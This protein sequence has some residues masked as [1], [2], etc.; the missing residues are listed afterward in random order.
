MNRNLHRIISNSR[1]AIALVSGP[2]R[3]ILSIFVISILIL[4][5]Y[6]I[7]SNYRDIYRIKS[8]EASSLLRSIQKAG[9][10]AYLS[11]M[12][13][14]SLVI[15]KLLNTAMF[16]SLLENKHGLSDKELNSI[17]RANNIDHIYILSETGRMEKRNSNAPYSELQLFQHFSGEIDSILSGRYDYFVAGTVTDNNGS[18]HLLVIH[19]RDDGNKGIIAISVESNYLL[20]FRMRIGVGKLF[21]KIADGSDIAYIAIQ[22]TSGIITA[23]K[24][25]EQLSSLRTDEFLSGSIKAR[26][27]LTREYDFKDKS[28]F[29]AVKPFRIGEDIAGIIRIGFNLDSLHKMALYSIVRTLAV[30]VLLLIVTAL[31]MVYIIHNRKYL[32]LQSDYKQIQN[33]TSRILESM[34]DAVV[35]TDSEGKLQLL[36]RS[37]EKLFG[38]DTKHA[39]GNMHY[40][41]A[42]GVTVKLLDKSIATGKAVEYMEEVITLNDGRQRILLG[43]TSIIPAPD[44]SAAVIIAVIRD[45]TDQRNLEDLQSRQEKLKLMGELAANVA[46]EIKNPLNLISITA[47]RFA[48]EFIP[49]TDR[50]EYLQ[51]VKNIR[52]EITRVTGIIDQ[53]LR[54]ARPPALK[55]V[56]TSIGELI[57]DTLVAF[58]SSAMQQDIE[59]TY[60]AD[61]IR[62]NIDPGQIKQVLFNL[63]QNSFEALPGKGK[64]TVEASEQHGMLLITVTDTGTGIKREDA[65]NIFNLYYTTKPG[66]TGQGLSIVNQIITAH[67]GKIFV[68]SR[69]G[70]TTRFIIEIPVI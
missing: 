41:D 51:L 22:D 34:S 69:P 31:T 15:D 20:E 2:A 16:I 68:E 57:S 6:D 25:V 56:N 12:E 14:E 7:Y 62:A 48:K 4:T 65:A 39:H 46:H 10:N 44:S 9:E 21:Q 54:F 42:A 40:R 52:Q 43:S 26:R 55:K 66:G 37:A 47:Q 30:S 49:V 50:D 58:Q 61:D 18:Q 38:V 63:I 33:Y 35:V 70:E 23:S 32:V 24:G 60:Q 59:L 27:I 45:L 5:S 1:N 64:I 8:I 3:T 28:V 53:F 29:E 19:K 11:S 17:S 67:G 36:N 13:V